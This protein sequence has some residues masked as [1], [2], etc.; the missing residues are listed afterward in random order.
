ML[1]VIKILE[2]SDEILSG[3]YGHT[4]R[5]YGQ[6]QVSLTQNVKILQSIFISDS[7]SIMY[8]NDYIN[9]HVPYGMLESKLVKEHS[10][11]S[12]YVYAI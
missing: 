3:G 10:H 12:Y 9:C 8:N 11:E 5:M 1:V 6:R 4:D 7:L 2:V